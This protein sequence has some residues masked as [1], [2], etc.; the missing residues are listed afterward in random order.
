MSATAY[1]PADVALEKL[2]ERLLEYVAQGIVLTGDLDLDDEDLESLYGF[3]H[4]LYQQ[5]R[6]SDAAKVF[7]FAALQ[8]CTERRF[9]IAWA[10]ALQMTGDYL[11]AIQLYTLASTSDPTDPQSCFHTC[12]CLVALGRVQDAREGLRI[13]IRQCEFGAHAQLAARAL[14]M[15]ELLERPL[16]SHTEGGQ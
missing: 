8:S 13:V 2:D 9:V 15:L 7:A 11:S 5:R 4:L 3:G 12:E 14:A 1:S 16:G 6:F 10:A